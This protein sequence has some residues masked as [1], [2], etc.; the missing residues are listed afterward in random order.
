[1]RL[2]LRSD[3]AQHQ[4]VPKEFEFEFPPGPEGQPQNFETKSTFIFSEQDLPGYKSKNRERQQ[5][6]AQNLPAHLLRQKDK[7]EKPAQNQPRGRRGR[8]EYYRKAIPSWCPL[9]T[10][11]GGAGAK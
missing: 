7:V 11:G 8:Q 4:N 6:V 9:Y 5:H 2:L 1:M 10:L 3:L